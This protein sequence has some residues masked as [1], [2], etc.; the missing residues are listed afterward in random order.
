[1]NKFTRYVKNFTPLVVW[2]IVSM[3]CLMCACKTKETVAQKEYKAREDRIKL[4]NEVRA[5]Y[6][7]D[8]VKT[9]VIRIDTLFDHMTRIDT[10]RVSENG[11]S[12]YYVDRYHTIEKI[13]TQTQTVIDQAALQAARD[14]I[15][16]RGFLLDAAIQANAQCEKNNESLKEDVLTLNL[17]RGLGIAAIIAM[18][19]TV[20]WLIYKVAKP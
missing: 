8:T 5:L 2:S 15:D 12:I 13:V 19:L 17:Y 18:A 4:L 1:M 20:V 7:C 16:N 11:D 10:V 9:E 14:S 6:P 3:V